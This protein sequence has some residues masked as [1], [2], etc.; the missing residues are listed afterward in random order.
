VGKGFPRKRAGQQENDRRQAQKQDGS[1]DHRHPAREGRDRQPGFGIVLLFF[2]LGLDFPLA[3]MTAISNRIWPAGLIDMALTLGGAMIL[4]LLFGLDLFSAF[5][6]L[7][8]VAFF[9]MQNVH[10]VEIRFLFFRSPPA[11]PSTAPSFQNRRR[12]HF[13]S[14]AGVCHEK[15]FFPIFMSDRG[16]H[17]RQSLLQPHPSLP[18]RTRTGPVTRNRR[19]AGGETPSCPFLFFQGKRACPPPEDMS[20]LHDFFIFMPY[21]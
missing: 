7:T 9:V 2:I 3:R 12:P 17:G 6:I 5:V 4:A 16:S 18:F 11:D 19:A 15:K 13:S 10:T 20:R 21:K 14:G 1:H 8:A